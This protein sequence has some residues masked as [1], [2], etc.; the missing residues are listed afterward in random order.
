MKSKYWIQRAIRNPGALKM[1]LRKRFGKKA[2]TKSGKIKVKY[3][4]KLAKEIKQGKIRV[5]N[6][7]T[8]LR[9]IYLAMTLKKLA[10]NK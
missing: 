5:R 10:K 2:F 1:W 6:K 3:L 7:R 4:R 9:R 8:I